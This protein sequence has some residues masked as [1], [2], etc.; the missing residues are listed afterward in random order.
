MED[1]A[2]FSFRICD[3][4]L[5]SGMPTLVL[6]QLLKV[7]IVIIRRTRTAFTLHLAELNVETFTVKILI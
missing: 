4:D 3:L 1:V 6:P 5:R 7:L 2:S